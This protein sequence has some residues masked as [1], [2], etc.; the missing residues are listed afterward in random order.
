MPIN[1]KKK[2]HELEAEFNQ[3]K[4]ESDKWCWEDV[5]DVAETMNIKMSQEQAQLVLEN[6]IRKHDASIGI[7]WDVITVYVVEWNIDNL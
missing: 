5:A 6:M 4:L 3:Y 2:Y 7:N 1:W